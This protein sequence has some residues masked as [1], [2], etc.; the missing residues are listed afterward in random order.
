MKNMPATQ[1][2]S[3]N[4]PA[5]EIP[6]EGLRLDIRAGED[7]CRDVAR[8]LRVRGIEGLAAHVELSRESGSAVIAVR[9]T[10]SA[11]VTQDCVV[12]GQK[13]VSEINEA[14]EA[15]YADREGAVSFLK[16]R[17]ER[18]GRMGDELQMLEEHDDPEPLDEQGGIDLGELAVQYLSLAVDPYPRSGAAAEAEC[19]PDGSSLSGETHRP[20]A[21][22]KNWK[23]QGKD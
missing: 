17:H 16:A 3:H 23:Q 18:L 21:A 1:E 13:M 20:F 12:S 5:G 2:W 10:V 6:A 22:L 7:E 14:F 15:Y 4:I 11:S 8:R 19:L 9:G